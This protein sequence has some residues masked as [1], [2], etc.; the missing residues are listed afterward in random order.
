MPSETS[1]D[2]GGLFY[3]N[4]RRLHRHVDDR[5]IN[6]FVGRTARTVNSVCAGCAT[7]RR[8]TK[9]RGRVILRRH[10]VASSGSSRIISLG[11]VRAANNSLLFP[12]PDT[13]DAS[14]M[15]TAGEKD[16]RGVRSFRAQFAS[17]RVRHPRA[18]VHTPY[19]AGCI[20]M[21]ARSCGLPSK[22][23][24]VDLDSVDMQNQ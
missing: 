9:C 2:A 14:L 12:T 7:I 20:R 6:P 24:H 5:E 21:H 16:R 17:C 10:N 1:S 19:A 3:V 18:G 13:T 4:S 11:C 8:L 15:T 22:I 23:R